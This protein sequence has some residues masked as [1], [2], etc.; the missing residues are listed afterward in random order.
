MTPQPCAGT[1]TC[2][3]GTILRN[4]FD[5]GRKRPGTPCEARAL[6]YSGGVYGSYGLE[7]PDWKPESSG[8]R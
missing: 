5:N 4:L 2:L 8:G 6:C 3:L 7:T 1:R